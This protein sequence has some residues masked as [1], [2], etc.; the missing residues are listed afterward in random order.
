MKSATTRRLLTLALASI[1]APAPA[2]SQ[3]VQTGDRAAPVVEQVAPPA[4]RDRFEGRSDVRIVSPGA[5]VWASFDRNLD[6]RVTDA[7]IDAVAPAAFRIAD[8]N[9]DGAL[10]GLEQGDWAASMGAAADVVANP[11]TFD[12]DLDKVV[13]EQEFAAGLRRLSVTLKRPGSDA[14]ALRDLVRELDRTPED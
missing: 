8:G 11:M 5:L 6:G 10:S 7:E 14:L 12:A 3:T 13:T 1:A 2:L 9:R 4:V